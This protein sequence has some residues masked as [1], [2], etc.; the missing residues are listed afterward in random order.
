MLEEKLVLPKSPAELPSPVKSKR[1]TAMPALVGA[2]R[3]ALGR[4]HV[5]SR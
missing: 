2:G 3:D 1:S 4:E 5:L